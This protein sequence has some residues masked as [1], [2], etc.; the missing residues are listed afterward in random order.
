MVAYYE[1]GSKPIPRVVAL[2]TFALDS[3]ASR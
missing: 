3:V 2:A 1:Q